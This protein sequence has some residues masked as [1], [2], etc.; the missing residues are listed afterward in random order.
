MS[1]LRARERHVH[2]GFLSSYNQH[3]SG[4]VSQSARLPQLEH[5]IYHF[6]CNV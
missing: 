1:R 4:E 2:V 3:R 6:I 5:C